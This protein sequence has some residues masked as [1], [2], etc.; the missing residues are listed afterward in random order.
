MKIFLITVLLASIHGLAQQQNVINYLGQKPPGMVA[1]LFAPGIV[2]T[3]LSEHSAPAFSPGGTTVLWTVMDKSFHGY[4]LEMK[5][6]S[7][8][9]SKPSRPSFADTTADDF[10]ASFSIDGKKLFFSSRRKVPA[11]YQQGT[12]IRIW[13]VDKTPGGWGKP[14]P[15]DTAVSKSG[16]Y[17]H[18]ITKNGTLYF[19]S[20]TTGGTGMNISRAEKAN[21]NYTKPKMLPFNIN[22][23]GYEDGPYISPHERFLIFESQRPGGVDGSLDLYI[24]FKNKNDQWGLPVNMG[25]K[26]N[27][28][29]SERFARLSPDGKYLF[30]GSSRNMSNDNWGFDIFWI[31]A[32]VIDELRTEANPATMIDQ[33]LGTKI[34]DA[35]QKNDVGSSSVLLEQWLHLY[36]DNLDALV[37]YLSILRKQKSYSEAERVL[38]NDASCCKENTSIIMEAGLVK[39]G[40]DKKDE[41]AKILS[42]LLLPGNQLRERYIY[43]SNSLLDMGKLNL[44]DGYFEKAMA[45][46]PGSFPYYDR[47]CALAQIGENER[48]IKALNKAADLG[49]ITRKDYESNACFESLK[50]DSGWTLLIDK[51]K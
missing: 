38:A 51:L 50:A 7:G 9:W 15:F 4:L 8:V 18:S 5:Y 46:S 40:L 44:S 21:G 13:Q 28:E 11:G 34:I 43:L 14:V 20:N 17:A 33:S 29:S 24:S 2:S 31:D 39:I 30:F 45:I 1:E 32:K 35:L 27:S 25:P 12:D 23:V 22:S 16:D 26:I 42:P 3:G 49:Y 10:Y 47:A 48:A 6:E 41:A 37:I 19:S 36:H